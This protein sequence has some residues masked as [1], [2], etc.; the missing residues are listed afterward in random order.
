MIAAATMYDVSTQEIWSCVADMPP[1]MCGNATLTIVVS[2]TCMTVASMID[3]VIMPRLS[4][5]A[6]A[7]VVA[8]AVAIA[9][10]SP[11][12]RGRRERGRARQ[13]R[14]NPLRRGPL[15]A[16]VDVDDGAHAGAQLGIVAA[17]LDRDADRNAL[18]RP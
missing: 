2:T 5:A 16:R 18:R 6:E 15:V 8:P 9:G 7:L 12:R 17:R 4:G 10:S 11:P 13:Q 3:T 14:A 1:C